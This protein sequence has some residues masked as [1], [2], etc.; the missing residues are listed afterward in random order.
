MEFQ[1]DLAPWEADVGEGICDMYGTFE[2]AGRPVPVLFQ[3]K[4]RCGCIYNFASFKHDDVRS[5]RSITGCPCV[6]CVC[7]HGTW[8]C[9]TKRRDLRDLTTIER[10]ALALSIVHMHKKVR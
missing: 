4:E 3:D 9:A 8:K 2:V 5:E 10:G 6:T 7:D 1:W